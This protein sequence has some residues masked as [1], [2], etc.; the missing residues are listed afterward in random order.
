MKIMTCELGDDASVFQSNTKTAK[1][2]FTGLEHSSKI[3]VDLFRDFQ[4]VVSD[5]V[6]EDNI[7]IKNEE[8][9]RKRTKTPKAAAATADENQIELPAKKRPRYNT[10]ARH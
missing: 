2:T 4:T 5:I 10:R 9:S 1:S 7:R 6:N 3:L 8:P